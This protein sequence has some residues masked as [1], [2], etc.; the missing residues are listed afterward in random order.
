MRR[1][2]EEIQRVKK[3]TF[4]SYQKPKDEKTKIKLH[5][6]S[7]RDEADSCGNKQDFPQY[8]LSTS[9]TKVICS[10]SSNVLYCPWESS[11]W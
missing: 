11:M 2:R 1:R 5:I 3:M 6:K 10:E 9:T 8:I 7:P 4:K